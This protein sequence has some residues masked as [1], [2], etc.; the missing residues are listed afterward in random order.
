M[1]GWLERRFR[2]CVV[3]NVPGS[4]PGLVITF[5]QYISHLE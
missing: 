4:S 1:L 5:Y 2:A 3:Q